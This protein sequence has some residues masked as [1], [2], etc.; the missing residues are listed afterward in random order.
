MGG[1]KKLENLIT[2]QYISTN[3]VRLHCVSAGKGDP[4]VL[5]HGFPEHWYSWR[6]QIPVLAEY[7]LVLAPDLRGYNTSDK[8]EGIDKYDIDILVAD[9]LGLIEKFGARR[10]T[11]IGHDWGG[12]LAWWLAIRHPEAVKKLIVMNC[13]HPGR[14]RETLRGFDQLSK[15]WYMFFFQLPWLPE[16]FIRGSDL[17]ASTARMFRGTSVQRSAF[18]DYDID[19]F[20]EAIGQ[21]GA[22]TAM[23]NYYR[24]AFRRILRLG[25]M[26]PVEAPTLLIWGEQD[27]FLVRGN[28][29]ELDRWVK[30]ITVRYLPDAGHWVQQERPEVVN[31]ML[32]EFLG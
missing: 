19:K 28:T 31:Q 11:V 29:E 9:I 15:S 20:A 27:R 32:R 26:P 18:T 25:P 23:I 24:A 8:P 1:D 3:G 7:G 14:F 30:D 21:P 2:S 4:I 5:L 16:R 6:H 10:A 17:R 12:A 13:P 22:L